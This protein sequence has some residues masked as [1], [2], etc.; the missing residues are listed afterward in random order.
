MW[1]WRSVREEGGGKRA[2]RVHGQRV[3]TTQ[4]KGFLTRHFVMGPTTLR[5]VNVDYRAGRM[6]WAGCWLLTRVQHVHWNVTTLTQLRE[7]EGMKGGGGGCD[8][9]MIHVWRDCEGH[10]ASWL[11]IAA[12]CEHVMIAAGLCWDP[13]SLR[14]HRKECQ[15]FGLKDRW[16]IAWGC[17]S[18]MLLVK[19]PHITA[20]LTHTQNQPDLLHLSPSLPFSLHLYH[21]VSFW[22]SLSSLPFVLFLSLSLLP[23]SALL[24]VRHAVITDWNSCSKSLEFLCWCEAMQLSVI[25]GSCDKSSLQGLLQVPSPSSNQTAPP[26]F[27]F[28]CS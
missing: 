25:I 23:S 9:D 26:Q 17:L 24:P 19:P 6:R 20:A 7:S 16:G 5:H 14:A 18:C 4:L 1:G 12:V 21:S 15:L 28:Y 27:S 3:S 10:T 22:A 2:E 13:A 8:G 11:A